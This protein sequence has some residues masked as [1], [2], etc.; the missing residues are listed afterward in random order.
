MIKVIPID[1]Y[2]T[3]VVVLAGID[4]KEFDDYENENK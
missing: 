2:I 1:I 4:E 3:N